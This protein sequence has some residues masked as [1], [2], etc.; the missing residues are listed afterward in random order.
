MEQ[1]GELN[2]L[3]IKRPWIYRI[4][5]MDRFMQILDNKELVFV[6]PACWSDPMEN[7]IFNARMIKDGQPYT[8]PAKQNIYG[9]CWS[10]NGDSYALWQIYTTKPDNR[11]KTR[12][13]IGIRITTEIDRLKQLSQ[14]NQGMFYYGLMDYKWKK[15]LDKLPKDAEFIKGLRIMDLDIHHLK[16]LLVK[17][18]SYAYENEFRLLAVPNKEHI[19]E[20]RDF[21]CRLKI[22]PKEF[23]SEILVDP[24]M[25]PSAFKK[26]KEKMVHKY[27]FNP[28]IVKRSTL[29]AAN[30]LVFDLDK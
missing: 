8:H 10:Y 19:D 29:A 5:L 28:R 30:R 21:L 11:G 27:G 2:S 18:R 17:R 20:S 14:H 15:D 16:T 22:E 1:I 24:I 4:E 7:I 6:R 26:F 12:R 9:Q 23:I 13:H 25:D 3:L